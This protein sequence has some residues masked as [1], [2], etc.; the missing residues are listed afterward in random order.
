MFLII[1]Q[2]QIPS[3]AIACFMLVDCV[4]TEFVLQLGMSTTF[5][6]YIKASQFWFSRIKAC[7]KILTES[8]SR[9]TLSNV[10]T[11]SSR[12]LAVTYAKQTVS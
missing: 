12:S 5:F 11:L 10:I 4:K 8:T 2:F 1:P 7:D 3:A 9:E 6:Q